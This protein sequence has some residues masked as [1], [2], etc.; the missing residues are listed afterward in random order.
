M[1]AEILHKHCIMWQVK[2][3]KN[4]SKT[5]NKKMEATEIFNIIH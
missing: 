1:R 3:Q 4:A 2:K 5:S